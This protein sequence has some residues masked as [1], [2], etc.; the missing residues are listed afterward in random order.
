MEKE[1]VAGDGVFF[2]AS[3][4]SEDEHENEEQEEEQEEEEEEEENGEETRKVT[5]ERGS[6]AGVMDE[7]ERLAEARIHAQQQKDW[8]RTLRQKRLILRYV[9]SQPIYLLFNP[10]HESTL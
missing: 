3:Y 4:F 1:K 6:G 7:A 5:K 10:W 8:L 9:H 2:I